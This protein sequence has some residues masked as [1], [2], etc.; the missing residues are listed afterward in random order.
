MINEIKLYKNLV[1]VSVSDFKWT[2]ETLF[3][4]WEINDFTHRYQTLKAIAFPIHSNRVVDVNRI[5]GFVKATEENKTIQSKIA[6]LSPEQK[7]QVNMTVKTYKKNFQKQPTNQW[8][9]NVIDKLLHPHKEEMMWQKKIAAW[10]ETQW[11]KRARLDFF[12]KLSKEEQL[13]IEKQAKRN[14]KE[15]INNNYYKWL[16]LIEKNK[17]LDEMMY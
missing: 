10:Q 1:E 15:N 13:Q 9:D 2:V 4:E 11:K 12:R 14:L 5:Q 6:S 16:I 3:W 7:E 17:I 8:I